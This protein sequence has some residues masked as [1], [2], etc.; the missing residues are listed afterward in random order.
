MERLN[1]H[2][3]NY[4]DIESAIHLNRYLLVKDICKGKKVLDIACGEGYGSKLI[5]EWGA[6]EVVGVDISSD[7]I[8][9]ARQTFNDSNIKF[10][11]MAADDKKIEIKQKFDL[12]VSLETIEHLKD[13]KQFLKNLKSLS[14]DDTVFVITCPNDYFY[15]P[16]EDEGNKYHLKKYKFIDF[17]KLSEEILGNNVQYM[18]G[19]YAG[20]YINKI[21]ND[22]DNSEIDSQI[23]MLDYKEIKVLS[24]PSNENLTFD[25]SCYYIGVWNAII[26]ESA[27]IYAYND[28]LSKHREVLTENINIK[29]ELA[30]LNNEKNTHLEK[31][32]RLENIIEI[33]EAENKALKSNLSI[34]HGQNTKNHIRLKSNLKK[35]YLKVR[36]FLGKIYRKIF[37][38]IKKN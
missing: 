4:S 26:D 1:I 37:R 2:N 24:I 32:N 30:N 29:N 13:P 23:K 15:Y 33:L 28:L 11:Q 3:Q 16:N 22:K 19:T 10:I 21:I 18:I 17:K 12:I 36:R 20:G 5:S 25:T 7:A 14:H 9:V 34:Y 38:Y 31:I 6:E 8:N 35:S 27:T